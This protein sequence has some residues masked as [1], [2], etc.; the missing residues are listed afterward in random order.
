MSERLPCLDSLSP[1]KSQRN[2]GVGKTN[3]RGALCGAPSQVGDMEYLIAFGV[4]S[5][6]A[7][8][9]VIIVESLKNPEWQ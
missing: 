6:A 8:C 3:C 7:L 5:I 1:P 4:A 9:A 2:C